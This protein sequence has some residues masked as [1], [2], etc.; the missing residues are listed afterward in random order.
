MPIQIKC[1]CGK[2]LKVPDFLFGKKARCPFCSTVITILERDNEATM[3]KEV[4]ETPK[5]ELTPQDLFENVKDTVV[6]IYHEE[7]SGSGFFLSSDGLIATNRH[8]VGLKNNVIVRLSDSKEIPGK[9][10]RSF[11]EVDLAFIKVEGAQ[12]K[13]ANLADPKAIKVGQSVCAIGYPR[14]LEN[15]LTKGVVSAVGRYLEGRHFIQTDAPI[16][17]GNSGG[18]L[19]NSYGEVIGVNTMIFKESQGLGFAVPVET[20][21]E[22]RKKLMGE[23]VQGSHYCSICGHISKGEKYCGFCGS[24]FAS[25]EANVSSSPNKSQGSTPISNC[26][27]CRQKIEP[28]T[29]YCSRCGTKI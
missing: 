8:V 24:S 6:G 11:R 10:V 5:P 7:G 29:K 27:V 26:P 15:T 12:V 19:F 22:C 13:W 25:I 20:L 17:P 4:K 21:Q 1:T 2:I 3:T 23:H 14:G 9:V 28:N 16:N 18:P